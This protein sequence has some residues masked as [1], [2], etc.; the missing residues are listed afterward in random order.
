[1]VQGPNGTLVPANAATESGEH[2]YLNPQELAA[3]QAGQRGNVYPLHP[4]QQPQQPHHSPYGQAPTPS[5]A[6]GH[7]AA[8]ASEER[9]ERGNQSSGATDEAISA[10]PAG[11]ELQNGERRGLAGSESLPPRETEDQGAGGFT[12]VNQ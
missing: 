10:G 3:A 2:L 9:G 5:A 11:Q 8:D 4:Q 12:A 7:A 1:M 6:N